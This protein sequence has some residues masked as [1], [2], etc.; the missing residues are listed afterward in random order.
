MRLLNTSTLELHEFFGANIPPYAILSHRWG[1]SEV[2]FQDLQN[3]TRAQCPAWD[4]ILG[5]CKRAQ[6][7]GYNFV[8]IDSCCIDKSSSAELSEAI[9]SMFR[10]YQDSQ[11]CYV[12]M[13]DVTAAASTTTSE[14]MV[15]EFRESLWFTRGWTLQELLAPKAAIFFNRYWIEIGTKASLKL[16]ISSITGI[17]DLYQFDRASIAQKMSWASNRQTLRPEDMA[18][19]LMGL[20]GVNMPLLYGEGINAFTRLQIEIMRISDDE[21]I[22]A[23]TDR[24]AP[25]SLRSG[26][27][28]RTPQAFSDSG[29]IELLPNATTTPYSM[30]NK[31]LQIQ[32]NLYPLTS[33]RTLLERAIHP[34]HGRRGVSTFLAPLSCARKGS[35][36]PIAITLF[37]LSQQKPE[38]ARVSCHTFSTFPNIESNIRKTIFVPQYQKSSFH[39]GGTLIYLRGF[40]Y[41]GYYHASAQFFPGLF[42]SGQ[43]K[44]QQADPFDTVL[45]LHLRS[46]NQLDGPRTIVELG[47]GI[48]MITFCHYT[49]NQPFILEIDVSHE[50]S[51]TVDILLAK[52]PFD[53]MIKKRLAA[54]RPIRIARYGKLRR[55]VAPGKE[56]TVSVEKQ[57]TEGNRCHLIN[58]SLESEV[59]LVPASAV[60]NL[61]PDS[62]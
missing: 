9:N 20:F 27:L 60:Q 29:D 11:V 23:W 30:T 54:D 46:D 26:L 40:H 21:S 62:S 33:P 6:E 10:W 7:D 42:V 2:T 22:F 51:P 59:E 34:S 31:G 57:G 37:Q 45:T 5:C 47:Y 15:L 50:G 35:L 24:T 38:Y 49:H 13:F 41:L 39:R 3:G 53:E 28:A 48:A 52:E 14:E 61:T 17:E 55:K 18:Y 19:C 8:W 36:D 44:S 58:F 16:L 12:Y 43:F 4:K 1:D 25:N 32:L 56:V